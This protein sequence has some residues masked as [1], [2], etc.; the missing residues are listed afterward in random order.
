[1]KKIIA[2]ILTLFIAFA[3][4]AQER[5]RT[6]ISA[7]GSLPT[8]DNGVASIKPYNVF[9]RLG[10]DFN[11]YI[12]IGFEGNASLIEDGVL[13]GVSFGINSYVAYLR[14]SIPIGED[15]R[16]YALIGPSNVEI[17]GN[18]FLIYSVSEE[19]NDTAVGI[20]FEKSIGPRLSFTADYINYY[21]KD[22]VDVNAF[23]LGFISY[24]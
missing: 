4:T 6:Y 16:I 15:A 13:S 21:D 12:G 5:P 3:A 7:G 22:D 2:G 24:F 11:E 9:F 8:F 14:G 18:A 20:G 1:M 23:N 19:D 10:F 17:T